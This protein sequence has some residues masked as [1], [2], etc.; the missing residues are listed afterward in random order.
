MSITLGEVYQKVQHLE[1][2]LV[3]GEAGLDREVVWT[4][5]VDSA[6]IS[7]F[8]QGKE[9]VLTTGIGLEENFSL[10][11]LVRKV[12]NNGASGIVIN[13]GHYI[14]RIGQDVKEFADANDFPVFEV[15]WKIHMAEI[16]RIVCF[17]IMKEQ[18][19]RTEVNTAL[20]CAC[21]SPEREELYVPLLKSKG[22]SPDG[23]YIAAVLRVYEQGQLISEERLEHL[24][25]VLNGCFRFAG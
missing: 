15:P 4:H 5:M 19:N 8:Q 13:I 11:Q 3:A 2:A 10:F 21:L 14:D 18:Q 17:D 9:L 12:Y 7:S 25:V 22:Y 1:M 24:S 23:I 6:A 20:T 16:E